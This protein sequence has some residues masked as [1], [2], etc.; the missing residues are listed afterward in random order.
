M[1]RGKDP[2]M[3]R[4]LQ[5][6]LANAA[7]MSAMA[8]SHDEAERGLSRGNPDRGRIEDALKEER[9]AAIPLLKRLEQSR[10]P[11]VAYHA[12]RIRA[13]IVLGLDQD[14][15]AALVESL[16]DL[17]DLDYQQTEAAVR[18]LC[19]SRSMPAQA[20][21]IIALHSLAADWNLADWQVKRVRE[22]LERFIADKIS[23]F[24]D[25]GL[26]QL[27]M[28]GSETRAVLLNARATAGRD[29][30]PEQYERWLAGHEDLRFHLN[31][32]ALRSEIT[33]LEKA[34]RPEEMFGLYPFMNDPSG[35][36]VIEQWFFRHRD[37]AA[38][39][40]IGKLKRME[41]IGLLECSHNEREPMRNYP[42]YKLAKEWF[43]DIGRDLMTQTRFLEA[44]W[45][46]EHGKLREG[47]LMA[48][49]L[50]SS[51]A[52]EFIGRWVRE[53]PET[54]SQPLPAGDGLTGTGMA[55]F[56]SG[57][58]PLD[59]KTTPDEEKSIL[60]AFD[61]LAKQ[62]EWLDQTWR[63]HHDRLY[64]LCMARQGRLKEAVATYT[65]RFDGWK[66]DALGR[67]MARHPEWIDLLEA[68]P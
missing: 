47:F 64:L 53:H 26:I 49:E 48:V 18:Q 54:W 13:W 58:A 46:A 62:E 37:F 20:H 19:E 45:L 56:L 67:L 14:I 34:G 5:V 25:P 59:P 28:I 51:A 35:R 68:E 10:T 9:A 22:T 16:L 11:D 57:I 23:W 61:H 44:A 2:T 27:E 40:D 17:P 52:G 43:P 41:I 66:P 50:Q 31:H 39:L 36:G 24:P 65:S 15:P 6:L 21:P 1:V 30:D 60:A 38:K 63:L 8:M 3:K 32:T 42:S 7:A 55:G 33:R 12:R 29:I 4:L